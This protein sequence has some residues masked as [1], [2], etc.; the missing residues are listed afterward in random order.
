MTP[1]ILFLAACAVLSGCVIGDEDDKKCTG[2]KCDG[3][4]ESC[5]DPAYGNGVC[6]P[7]LQ[8]AAPDIDCFRTFDDDAAA[9]TW[10]ADFEA[11][12]AAE[13]NRQP[14]K[15]LT[16][17]DPRWAKTRDL[18][19]RGWEA[20]KANRP[21]GLL[22]EKRPA[23]VFLEDATPNAFV[24]PDLASGKAGFAV[25]VLTG[26]FE[27][28]GTD[29]GAMGVMMHEF[30]HA[31][32][33][34][35]VEGTRDRMRKFYFARGGEPIG[36]FAAEDMTARRYGETWR[37]LAD[38]VGAFRAEGL[39]AL[40]LG[41]QFQQALQG[42]IAQAGTMNVPACQT[43]RAALG[44][45]S[46]EVAGATDPISGE[47]TVAA[48]LATRVDNA[49]AQLKSQCFASFTTDIIGVIA[50]MTGQTPAAIEA[51]MQPDDIALVKGKNVVDGFA[52]VVL[53]RRAKMRA[54][55]SEL[56]AKTGHAWT[57]LR[58]FSTEE[59]ADD[60]SVSVLRDA[61]IDPP[62][63]IGP[64]LASFLPGD[65]R[66]RCE[67][68]IAKRVVPPYHADLSDEHHGTCWRRH[69]A[70]QFA[71]EGDGASSS[72]RAVKHV[73]PTIR[74]PKPLPLPRPLRERLAY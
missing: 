9:A 22:S 53:D 62:D 11:Q 52:A 43:A 19:D 38:D 24:A 50:T 8:C 4:G 15:F 58:Y 26:L 47:V 64:F 13:E 41:G 57:T 37:A 74:A 72:A 51:A 31:V 68:M 7:L 5:D 66:A 10:F 17:S 54:L 33:L 61:G 3:N 45:L 36:K 60:V 21:V 27:T 42:A 6:D 44:T 69:H 59:D 2:G 73:E 67:D 1:R 12:L 48:N 18:L 14:R 71:E 20:F 30:Q 25:M 70:K 28:G 46:Q 29:D 35:V 39:R 40:P 63:A 65:G 56:Q 16:P 55:E 34:H 49:M 32:G 23:L